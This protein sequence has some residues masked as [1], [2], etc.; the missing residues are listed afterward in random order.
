[1]SYVI[2]LTLRFFTLRKDSVRV[3]QGIRTTF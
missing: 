3:I 1:M 2:V